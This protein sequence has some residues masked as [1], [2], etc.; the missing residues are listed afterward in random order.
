MIPIL[1]QYLSDRLYRAANGS[2]EATNDREN[3]TETPAEDLSPKVDMLPLKS[4]KSINV[5]TK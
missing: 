1:K 2:G 4:D 5:H 3:D